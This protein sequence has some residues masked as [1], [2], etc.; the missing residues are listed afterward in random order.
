MF[1]LGKT[2]SIISLINYLIHNIK[3]LRL[4]ERGGEFTNLMSHRKIEDLA[5]RG[6]ICLYQ[7]NAIT[8]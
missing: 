2:C 4:Y 8:F 1:I 3:Y 5:N 6:N 7:R